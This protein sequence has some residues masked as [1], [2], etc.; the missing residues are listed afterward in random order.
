MLAV[1]RWI[2]IVL[3][4]LIIAAG[5]LA[6][7]RYW[8]LRGSLPQIDGERQVTGI[9][10]PV[11]ILRDAHGIPRIRAASLDD[12]LYGLGF[13]HAQDRL[14]QMTMFR[15]VGQGR[16]A[17]LFGSLAVDADRNLRAAGLARLAEQSFDALDADA[18]DALRAYARGVNAVIEGEHGPKAEGGLGKPLP[19]EFFLTQ[20]RPEP[21]APSDSLILMNILSVG[22]SSNA[23]AE[24]R[25]VAL[26]AQLS[27]GQMAAFLA[28][29]PGLPQ[30]LDPD[31]WETLRA[32]PDD[33]AA[34]PAG[35][36]WA[37]AIF[38][39]MPASNN[40]A[41]D[42]QW[43]KT[44]G[45]ILA[46]DPHL[47]L[48]AP[49]LWYLAHLYWDGRNAIGAT[50]AGIPSILL[51]RTDDV[52]WGFTT[53]NADVQDLVLE[54]ID[55]ADPKAYLTP[56]GS[57]PFET[58]EETIAVRFGEPV[59]A[60]IR[61]TRNGPLIPLLQDSAPD[62]HAYALT[63][64][65]LTPRNRSY[66]SSL[67]IL[68][69]RTVDEALD[70]LR[71]YVSPVQSIVIADTAGDVALIAAGA[72]PV[73]APETGHDGTVPIAG[74]KHER[75]WSGLLAFEDLPQI[76]RPRTGQVWSANSDMRPDGYPHYITQDWRLPLRAERV[77]TLL[78]ARRDHDAAYSAAMMMDNR[79]GLADRLLPL[80]LAHKARTPVTEDALARLR[81]WDADMGMDAPEPLILVAW[82]DAL[83]PLIATD[84]L[85]P[86]APDNTGLN[87][88]FLANVLSDTDGQ[89]V[90]C[91]DIATDETETCA[92]RLEASLSSALGDLEDRFGSDPAAWR[93]GAAHTATHGHLPFGFVPVLRTA[94]SLTVETAGGDY[95]VNRG[96]Y[97][98]G[99]DDPFANRHAA[100]YRAVYDMSERLDGE[101]LPG[102]AFIASTG[103]SGNPYSPL[104][105]SMLDE[106]AEGTLIPMTTNPAIYE[107]DALGTLAFWPQDESAP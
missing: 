50:M 102:S 61:T 46:N 51:G 93:W 94:F 44:G 56:S 39:A 3:L 12:A 82:L 64:T 31:L 106:W 27:P 1:L 88:V 105:R 16:L 32:A 26:A 71:S 35:R 77:E 7:E 36:D 72:I 58:R 10:A 34:V 52:S 17:E 90:W 97:R 92:D 68:S 83:V 107:S 104:Y 70:A 19:P 9:D 76:V 20:S 18:Q 81:A 37:Q 95:T 78:A 98:I 5:A 67:D 80:L 59:T 21:W 73:R 87:P 100:G 33:A 2:G 22:L 6:L 48:T 24:L 69:A 14:W 11:S 86:L 63:W 49:S 41:V 79:T 43:T 101:A 38:A 13:A 65:A 42:G 47:G 66:Q 29:A 91:D 75:I 85:G 84:E 45:A 4:V 23:S 25:R 103:Q 8:T 62:G 96:S 28:P 55:P 89:A 30:T 60:T 54:R 57:A 15:R 74:W 40:W 53:T 99:A